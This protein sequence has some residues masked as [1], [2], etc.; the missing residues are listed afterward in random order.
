MPDQTLINDFSARYEARFESKPHE[1]ASLAYDGV[2]AIGA[3]ALSGQPDAL[4]AQSLQQPAGFEGVNGI[5]RFKE[6]GTNER[7]LAIAQIV[8][9]QVEIIDPAPQSFDYSGY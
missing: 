8:N 9:K 1:L 2:A 7:G 3:L 4:S 6:D 5:F